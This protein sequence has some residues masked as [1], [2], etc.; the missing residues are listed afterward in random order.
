M[1]V[2]FRRLAAS[3]DSET[4][5]AVW[6]ILQDPPIAG[7]CLLLESVAEDDGRIEV[8]QAVEGPTLEERLATAKLVT[9]EVAEIVR[10]LARTLAALH[11]RNLV[12]LQLGAERVLL[13]DSAMGDARL[14]RI[15]MCVPV[16]AEGA[17]VPVPTDVTRMPPEGLG[18]YRMKADDHLKAWDWWT[19]GRLIQELWLSNTVMAHSLGRDLGRTSEPVRRRAEEMLKEANAKDPRAG[20]VEFMTDLPVQV[21]TLLRGLLTSVREARWGAREVMRWLEGETPVE[22][23]DLPR[24]TVLIH[25]HDEQL[26][27]ADTALR[28]LQPQHWREGLAW[29]AAENPPEDSLPAVLVR[30]RASLHREREWMESVR[31]LESATAI[32]AFSAEV[33]HEILSALAWTGIAGN[34]TKF[35]WR[36]AEVG[37]E[38][39]AQ[40]LKEAGGLERLGAMISRGI[41]TL[42]KRVDANTA[43][44]LD[45]WSR[46]IDEVKALAARHKW[47]NK[48]DKTT[49]R[50]CTMAL[51][52]VA[53]L[54]R[55]FGE[56]RIKYRLSNDEEIQTLFGSLNPTPAMLAV[57]ALSFENAKACGYVTHE[58]WRVMELQRLRA[59][60]ERLTEALALVEL[61]GLLKAGLP[62]FAP[63]FVWGAGVAFMMAV[64]A[65]FWPGWTGL[66]TVLSL[67]TALLVLRRLLKP[68][69]RAQCAAEADAG[70]SWNA[71]IDHCKRRARDA[72]EG[73]LVPV[74]RLRDML[75]RLNK[76][77][78]KLGIE[79]PPEPVLARP[80]DERLTYAAWGS[81]LV[82]LIVLM[83]ISWQAFQPQWNL[84][85]SG[86]VW[87]REFSGLAVRLGLAE[88]P[89]KEIEVIKIDWPHRVAQQARGVTFEER[90]GA[91]DAHRAA[92]DAFIADLQ[93]LY[94]PETLV[95]IAAID[96]ST[97]G[98]GGAEL[99]LIDVA[100]GKPMNGLVYHMAYVPLHGMWI[101][102]ANRDVVFLSRP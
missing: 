83:S 1:A 39:A 43:W 96:V 102:L 44:I 81:W 98:V 52:D 61:M 12:Y 79:P 28:L 37:P 35:R 41:V 68:V 97:A 6:K 51:S 75:V 5:R 58:E 14:T 53:D 25:F 100:A 11:E 86:E 76:E 34:K 7:G 9:E 84:A 3:A 80:V 4:R 66:V 17:L 64:S 74:A 95:G 33:R 99:M 18:L 88:E 19:L 89:V 65:A 42:V 90:E 45:N 30:T 13:A 71:A 31:E 70:W 92:V 72:L 49:A 56:A 15:E 23:Y 59:K 20:G 60:G 78:Q 36:G 16:N 73:G 50:L 77:I 26:T 54:D 27:V 24:S 93:R 10:P 69:V 101:K 8:W 85:W 2:R 62:V 94:L 21:K 82:L 38:L 29:W 46:Q 22:R 55:R 91:T 63:P 32:K 40:V 48:D 47:V 57:L 67:G 87:R